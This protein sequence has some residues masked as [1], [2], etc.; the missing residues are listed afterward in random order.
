M[1]CYSERFYNLPQIQ[2]PFD[3]VLPVLST[4]RSFVQNSY[5]CYWMQG[6]RKTDVAGFCYFA[7]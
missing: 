7:V 1:L 2:S 6:E 3:L 5:Q 4:K